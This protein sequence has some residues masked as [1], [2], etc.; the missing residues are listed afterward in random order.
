MNHRPDADLYCGHRRLCIQKKIS[1]TVTV[2]L[3]RGHIIV[4]APAIVVSR[5]ATVVSICLDKRR[6]AAATIISD[7]TIL[8]AVGSLLLPKP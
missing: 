7:A 4:S 5:A 6:Y 1:H 8:S 3:C 2:G